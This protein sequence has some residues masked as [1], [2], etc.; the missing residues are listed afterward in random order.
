MKPKPIT[1]MLKFLR[2]INLEHLDEVLRKLE[3]NK[4]LHDYWKYLTRDEDVRVELSFKIY[5]TLIHG[6]WLKDLNEDYFK[7]MRHE[8]KKDENK[9]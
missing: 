5:Y 1:T 2:T 6:S 4:C 8:V 7:R 9:E 3:E